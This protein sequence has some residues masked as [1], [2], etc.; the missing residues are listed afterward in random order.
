MAFPA[1]EQPAFL[2]IWQEAHATLLEP[3]LTGT[4]IWVVTYL[5]LPARPFR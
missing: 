2:R 1:Y 4:A 3:D 5:I